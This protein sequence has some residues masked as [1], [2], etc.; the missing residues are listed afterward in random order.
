MW[1]VGRGCTR[2]MDRQESRGCKPSEEELEAEWNEAMTQSK[3]LEEVHSRT[4]DFSETQRFVSAYSPE[5]DSIFLTHRLSAH[6]DE[7]QERN[8]SKQEWNLC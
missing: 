6:R 3:K 7:S 1:L 2:K 5:H 8:V 4:F